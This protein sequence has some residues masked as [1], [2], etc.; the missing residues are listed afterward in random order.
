M[1]KV[2]ISIL[3]IVVLSAGVVSTKLS[4]MQKQR[5]LEALEKSPDYNKLSWHAKKAK[6]KGEKQV[7]LP[8]PAID[9]PGGGADLNQALSNFSV[10]IV[11]PVA[12]ETGAINDYSVTNWYKV[13]VLEYLSKKDSPCITCPTLEQVPQSLLPLGQDE[14][15][16]DMVG[17]NM[18]IDGVNITMAA[19]HFPLKKSKKYLLLLVT[20]PSGTA[21]IG[22][23]PLGAF[24]I[25]DDDKLKPVGD[26]SHHL[27]RDMISNFGSDVSML[28]QHLKASH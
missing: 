23:G 16:L 27:A 28:R 25:D 3:A 18:V 8:A 15:V 26:A 22:A 7:T 12:S 10:A 14:V 9:Y 2:A 11:Q 20:N 13:K 4:S 5:E 24:L 6:L 19:K 17:G 1:V 21:L